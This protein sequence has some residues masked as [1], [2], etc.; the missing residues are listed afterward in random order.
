VPHF[1]VVTA[2]GLEALPIR[3]WAIWPLRI[4]STLWQQAAAVQKALKGND[5]ELISE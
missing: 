1:A 2:Y 3:G 4:L 5:P